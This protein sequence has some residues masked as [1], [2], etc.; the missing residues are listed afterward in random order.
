MLGASVGLRGVVGAGLNKTRQPQT[1]PPITAHARKDAGEVAGT[2][3]DYD[4]R[5]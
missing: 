3:P 1:P 2:I 5:V 4:S